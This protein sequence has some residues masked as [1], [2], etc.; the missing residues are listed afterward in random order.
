L[1]V[2]GCDTNKEVDAGGG[3]KRL[4]QE[5]NQEWL[6]TSVPLTKDCNHEEIDG[7]GEA[8]RK[9]ERNKKKIHTN[10]WSRNVKGRLGKPK[11]RKDV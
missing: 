4:L 5:M 9:R 1:R 2:E 3:N 7:V 11:A 10:S 6:H 8:C